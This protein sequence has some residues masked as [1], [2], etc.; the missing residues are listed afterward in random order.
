MTAALRQ[1]IRDVPLPWSDP[2]HTCAWALDVGGGAAPLVVSAPLGQGGL[3]ERH[4]LRLWLGVPSASASG[5]LDACCAVLPLSEI[6]HARRFRVEADATAW[7][8]AHAALRL[9]LAGSLECAPADLRFGAGQYGKPFLAGVTGRSNVPD[10][11]FNISHSR[12]RVMVGLSASPVGVDVQPVEDM[13][14]LL[15]VAGLVFAPQV[16]SM[17]EAAQGARR[18]KLFYRFWTLGE[19]YIKAT[20]VG[21]S[22][23]LQSFAFSQEGQ[24]KLERAT[25]GWGPTER[26]RFGLYPDEWT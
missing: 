9:M 23:G 17:L 11:H 8:A 7:L 15:S 5:M 3:P 4:E 22:Q 10:I 2:N 21:V 25:P 24:A 19:A 16:V 14:D 1:L 20:G 13:P 26:W 6:A 18:T 12:T